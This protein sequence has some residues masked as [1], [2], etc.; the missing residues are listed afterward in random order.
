MAKLIVGERAGRMGMLA[1]G[2]SAAVFDATRE[3]ILLVQRADDGLWAVPGGYMEPGESLTEACCREV[4]EE[5]GLVVRVKG[6]IAAY[7][8][9]DK[10]LV[11]PDGNRWQ[12]V[13]LHFEAEPIGGTL[14]ASDET[15]A[16]QFHTPEEAA[17]LPMGEFDRLRVDDAFAYQGAAI[18]HDT[19]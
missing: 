3:H 18:I 6:L 4:L 17:S 11:Y 2:C 7:T 8:N 5:T 16:V 10:L 19:F 14:A 15:V 13:V 9:P 1:V 12:L